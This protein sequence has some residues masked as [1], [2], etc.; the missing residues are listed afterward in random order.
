MSPSPRLAVIIVTWNVRELALQCLE[1]VYADLEQGALDKCV[2]VVDN[3]SSDGTADAIRTIYPQIHLLEAGA[4]L[5]FGRGNNLALRTLGSPDSPKFPDFV[6]LLN[7]D[8]VVRPGALKSLLEGMETTK[9][10]LGGARLVYG[11]GSFQHSAFAFPGLAQIYIDLFP[12]PG[13]LRESRINGRYPRRLYEGQTPFEIDFPLGATFCVRR[14]VIRQTGMFDE[15]FQLYCEEIDWAIR[16]RRAGWKA[17]CVPTSEIVHFGGQSTAQVKSKSIFNLWTARLRLYRKHYSRVKRIAA[18]WIVRAGME[19]LIQLT[20]R[21]SSQ[22]D[23]IRERL[24][25]A[26]REIIKLSHTL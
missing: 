19:R 21:D 14:E 17:V 8:T 1:S 11:D 5:G 7:P 23:A 13:R 18:G 24:V 16:I 20:A 12:V 10:G 15:E 3:A 9:A 22:D 2:Y 4:N 6:L 25:D 26:Y